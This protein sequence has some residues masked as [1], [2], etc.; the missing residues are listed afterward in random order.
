MPEH[1]GDAVLVPGLFQVL[2][3]VLVLERD[4]LEG[5]VAGIGGPA[6]V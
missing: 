3:V 6:D 4:D 5:V 1:L 2:L